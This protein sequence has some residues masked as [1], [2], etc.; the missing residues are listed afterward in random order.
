MGIRS[1]LAM[2]S[3]QVSITAAILFL[4][5]ANPM[6]FNIVDMG[7]ATILGGII[8]IGNI[9]LISV[10]ERTKEIGIRRAIGATPKEIRTQIIIESVFLTIIAGITGIILGALV[11]FSISM[12]TKGLTDYPFTNP[13]VPLNLLREILLLIILN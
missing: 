5:V 8:G 4:I 13:T 11:L 2:K 10:K 12:A 3:V 7:L 1:S 6:L 9:L